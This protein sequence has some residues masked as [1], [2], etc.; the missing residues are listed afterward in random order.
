[1]TSPDAPLRL[2]VVDDEPAIRQ[3]LK[4]LLER[5]FPQAGVVL[6]SNAQDALG[7]LQ[8]VRV[9]LVLSDHHMPGMDGVTLLTHAR[10]LAPRA[11]R[12]LLTAHADFR[13]AQRAV[14]EG[15]VHGFLQK[16]VEAHLLVATL[17]RL[18]DLPPPEAAPALPVHP[19]RPRAPAAQAVTARRILVVDDVP[20]AADL[21]ALFAARLPPGSIE[22]VPE[23]D[24]R[25]ALQRLQE[26]TFAAVVT[27]YRMPHQ[28]GLDVLL[29]AQRL[30]PAAHRILVTGYNEIPE[31]LERL[32]GARIDAYL[33]KPI[34]A[35]SALSLLRALASTDP[36]AMDTLRAQAGLLER[37]AALG[38]DPLG[39]D[40]A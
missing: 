18:L 14:N 37:A 38:K 3:S 40:D 22:V 29:H 32:R 8:S 1:M 30:Q 5:A 20:P 9:D 23:H 7:V 24:P 31:D 15:Q 19:P 2:L 33:H 28:S 10:A 36:A 26:E 27:D 6:A 34:T 4:S 12:V 16:P 35:Q 21:F 25:R 39:L 13:A 17:A 11:L